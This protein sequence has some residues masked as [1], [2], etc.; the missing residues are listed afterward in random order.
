MSLRLGPG[1]AISVPLFNLIYHDAI[2]TPYRTEDIENV[3]AGLLNG[4]LPRVGDLETEVEKSGD[5]I[6]QMSALIREL[7]SRDDEA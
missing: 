5:W 1:K 2:I 4:G 6:R 7:R 3:L